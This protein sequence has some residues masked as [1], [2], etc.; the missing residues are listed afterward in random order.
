[1]VC[2]ECHVSRKFHSVDPIIGPL[3]LAI[4]TVARVGRGKAN[5]T[6]NLHKTLQFYL[7]RFFSTEFY[8]IKCENKKCKK[9]NREGVKNKV[10]HTISDAPEILTIQLMCFENYGKRSVQKVRSHVKYSQ[11]L[12][13]TAHTSKQ[14]QK[15]EGDLT[16]RL[17]SVIFHHGSNLSSGHYTC[18]VQAP[19]GIF[20]INDGD[21]RR[22]TLS[23]MIPELTNMSSWSTP[24]ILTYVRTRVENKLPPPLT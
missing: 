15:L 20:K 10:T 7:D 19:T 16:Y 5:E 21:V 18:T 13:L 14:F 6:T 12:D 1:M 11:W 8:D 17:S 9:H 4:S 22:A 2:H 24:Y 3:P 23:D